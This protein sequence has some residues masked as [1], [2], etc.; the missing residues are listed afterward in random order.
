M[1]SHHSHHNSL[2]NGDE[3]RP[4]DSGASTPRAAISRS[5]SGTDIEEKAPSLVPIEKLA[6][7]LVSRA[8]KEDGV[9]GITE[10]S[11]T[12]YLFPLYPELGSRLF[13]FLHR[14]GHSKNKHL[15]SSCFR[16]QC[17][18]ILALIDDTQI[19]QTYVQMFGDTEDAGRVKSCGLTALLYTSYQLSMDHYPEGPRTCLS[20]QKTLRAVSE[21]CFG[22]EESHSVGFVVRWLERNCGRAVLPVHRYCVHVLGT[23]HRDL[24]SLCGA[25]CSSLQLATPVLERA[26]CERRGNLPLSAA[27]LLAAAAPPAF[28]AP[29]PAPAVS[30][31]LWLARLVC[32]APSHWVPLYDS[33]DHGLGLN[34]F[35][36]HTLSY[37]GPTL[38]VLQ[39]ETKVL[40]LCCGCEW[41]DSHQ[42]WGDENCA[43]IRLQPAFE[44]LERAPKMIYLNTSIRGYPKGLRAGSDPRKPLLSIDED[45]DRVS[46]QGAPYPLEAMEVWGCGDAT[47]RE[48][49]LEIKKWQVKEAEKQGKVKLSAADWMDHPDRYLLELA[50][51]PQYN[52]K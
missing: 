35:L 26:P 18:K 36:H 48:K 6:K 15:S 5:G 14:A 13:L 45:F 7:L 22:N 33:R 30:P 25:E 3:K 21:G 41:R 46:I 52:S 27:W 37:R 24:E 9:N 38:V 10:K 44:V 28:A 11:F 43:L 32:L 31:R 19:I 29:A 42:Y 23:R 2:P 16:T 34:R 50:G 4:G 47:S 12:K 39:A 20:I 1:G 51:R 49:Q 40:V 17:E 8:Q